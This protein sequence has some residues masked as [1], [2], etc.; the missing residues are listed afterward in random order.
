MSRITRLV[1]GSVPIWILVLVS[2]LGAVSICTRSIEVGI[3]SRLGRAKSPLNHVAE[4]IGT[5]SLLFRDTVEVFDKAVNEKRKFPQ[6]NFN[7]FVSAYSESGLHWN[8]WRQY[9]INLLV[10]TLPRNVLWCNW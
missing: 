4:A 7:Q 9:H 1:S 5:T 10:K 6:P 3:K 8:F 2:L